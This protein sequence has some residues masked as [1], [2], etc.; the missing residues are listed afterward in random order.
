LQCHLGGEQSM[1]NIHVHTRKNYSGAVKKWVKKELRQVSRLGRTVHFYY[2][3][4]AVSK[5]E[6]MRYETMGISTL[7]V[8]YHRKDTNTPIIVQ[9]IDDLAQ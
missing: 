7:Q 9:L 8:G 2:N 5:E 6:F 1:Q 4:E 3:D